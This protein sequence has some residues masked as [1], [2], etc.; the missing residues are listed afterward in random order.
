[1]STEKYWYLRSPR[2]LCDAHLAQ[3]PTAKYGAVDTVCGAS[4]TPV[5]VFHYGSRNATEPLDPRV[6]ADCQQ[7]A[8]AAVAALP[9]PTPTTPDGK[10]RLSELDKR[11]SQTLRDPR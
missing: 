4:F 2:G 9:N 10:T 3:A 11:M 6:C 1:M 8:V 5:A 7:A